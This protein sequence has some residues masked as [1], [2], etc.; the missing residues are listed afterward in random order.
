MMATGASRVTELVVAVN[1][2]YP[3]LQK[4]LNHSRLKMFILRLSLSLVWSSSY[5]P[6]LRGASKGRVEMSE[7]IFQ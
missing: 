5:R 4:M 3:K 6:L 1:S 7:F 2:T